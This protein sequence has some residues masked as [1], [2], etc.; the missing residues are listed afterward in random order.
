MSL[1]KAT[2]VRLRLVRLEIV[3]DPG[4]VGHDAVPAIPAERPSAANSCRRAAPRPRGCPWRPCWGPRPARRLCRAAPGAPRPRGRL[5]GRRR[6]RHVHGAARQEARPERPQLHEQHP[7]AKGARDIICRI[8]LR[9]MPLDEPVTSNVNGFAL[10]SFKLN[11]DMLDRTARTWCQSES[12]LHLA[13]CSFKYL[14][15]DQIY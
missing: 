2:A 12:L 8:K 15:I 3:R 9:P 11:S 14:C 1:V 7:H 6:L 5:V 4:R 13:H 10:K